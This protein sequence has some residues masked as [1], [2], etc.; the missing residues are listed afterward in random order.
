M[1]ART[2]ESVARAKDTAV[3]TY[4]ESPPAVV[5]AGA[6]L[7]ALVGLA[8]WRRRRTRRRASTEELV[9]SV[10]TGRRRAAR[11]AS[12]E[13]AARQV[14]ARKATKK[15]EKQARKRARRTTRRTR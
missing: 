7:A 13:L 8:L 14:A 10:R 15:A 3:E 4:R 9:L 1:P 11:R 5:G 12:K 6:G 2:R